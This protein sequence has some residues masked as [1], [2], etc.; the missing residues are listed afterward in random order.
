MES[1]SRRNFLVK[2]AQGT[3]MI[4]LSAVA[5]SVLAGCSNPVSSGSALTVINATASNNVIVIDVSSGSALGSVGSAAIVSYG[6][7]AILVDHP[8]AGT[9]HALSSVCNHQGCVITNY[10]SGTKEF[11]CPCH[12]SRFSQTG[13]LDQGPASA[14]LLSYQTSLS[15][16]QLTITL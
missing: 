14:G 11:V 1:L 15:G 16:N 6:S 4:S 5:A 7:S 2:V 13:G 3:A 12:G 8:A 9:Y 10:D